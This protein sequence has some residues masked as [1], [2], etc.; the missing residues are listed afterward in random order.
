[1][2]KTV[3]ILEYLPEILVPIREFQAIA[4]AENPEL[5]DLWAE[6]EKAFSDQ[7]VEDA[8]ANG[9]ARYES[10]LKIVPKATETLDERKFKILAR[11]NEQ[12]PYTYRALLER[13]DTLCGPDGYSVAVDVPGY[14]VEVRVALTASNN[15]DAVADLLENIVPVNMLIDLSLKYNQHSLL[16]TFT[17]AQLSA[18][19]HDQ[20]R[21]EVIS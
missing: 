4:T 21:N 5:T 11:Y 10:I 15:F 2:A 3:D 12:L 7:Y 14:T 20:L 1:M 17:H 8:T 16:A 19:T 6:I 18:Y 13:L 9:V